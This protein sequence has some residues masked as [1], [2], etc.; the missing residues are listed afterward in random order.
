MIGFQYGNEKCYRL[1]ERRSV[2][3]LRL[4]RHPSQTA[5]EAMKAYS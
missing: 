2:T 1:P 5:D 3:G 4:K